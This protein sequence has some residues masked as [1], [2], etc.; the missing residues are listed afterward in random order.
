MYYLYGLNRI[1]FFESERRP[2][3]SDQKAGLF[4]VRRGILLP[5]WII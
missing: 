5:G 1:H 3:I 4:E 2:K